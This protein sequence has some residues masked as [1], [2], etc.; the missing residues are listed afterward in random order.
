MKR[1]E[2]G[3]VYDSSIDKFMIL[4]Y[5]VCVCVFARCLL[6]Q[7]KLEQAQGDKEK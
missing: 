1:N 2:E 4:L 3:K 7:Y 5:Y 6:F